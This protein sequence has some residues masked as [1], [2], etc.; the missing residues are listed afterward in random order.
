MTLAHIDKSIVEYP[1]QY[2]NTDPTGGRLVAWA[3]GLAA[4]HRIGSAL[5]ETS[6]APQHFR[7]KPGDAAAAIL[8]GDEIG[9]TPTQALRSIYVVSGNPGLYAKAMVALVLSHGHEVWTDGSTDAQVTVCGRRKGTTHVEKVTWT[10]D[11]ARKA[12]YT[13]NK[14]YETDPQ[15]MLY[16]RAAADVCRRIA[17]DSLAGISNT[18]EELEMEAAPSTAKSVRRTKITAQVMPTP[19]PDLEPEPPAVEV[20]PDPITDAQVKKIHVLV[21]AV[22]MGG[23]E[24]RDRKLRAYAVITGRDIG[25]TTELTK[26]EASDIIRSLEQRERAEPEPDWDSADATG[27]LPIDTTEPTP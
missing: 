21:N 10:T 15:A 7:G 5:C 1:A 18:V 22:G 13:S 3:D 14:K 25:S 23:N 16:A 27:S 20:E 17:P 24:N 9:F 19:E 8:F 12:G 4:A 11:R 26:A 6:F 2:G